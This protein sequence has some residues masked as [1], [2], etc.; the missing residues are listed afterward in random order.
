MVARIE[1]QKDFEEKI[2]KEISRR[3]QKT[4]NK[5]KVKAGEIIKKE[6]VST[7]SK[8]LSP[9]EGQGRF[10]TYS[11][12]YKEA[13]NSGSYKKFGKK[14]SPVNLKLSGKMLKSIKALVTKS[15]ITIFFSSPIAKYHN[16]LGASK[17]KVIRRLLPKEGERFSLTITE[18]ISKL[19]KDTFKTIR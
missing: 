19:I 10:Q 11:K 12:S 15:G 1:I 9:I 5:S 14:Q 4:I 3:A 2:K 17:K 13:I 18:K 7:I 16:E 6:V 8:G